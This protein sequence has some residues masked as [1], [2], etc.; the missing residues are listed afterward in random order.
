MSATLTPSNA[1]DRVS[2]ISGDRKI[3]QV[4]ETGHV[5]AVA[6]GT[7]K[8]TAQTQS[9]KKAVC[10][11]KVVKKA[12]KATR[13]KLNKRKA[14]LTAGGVLQLKATLAPVG[15]TDELKWSSSNRKVASVDSN[16][17]V[18]AKKAG[19]A[20]IKVKAKSGKSAVCTVTVK[21]PAKSV[22]INKSAVT[23]KVG[24]HVQ[25]KAV[26]KP[27]KS[28][29]RLKWSSSDKKIARV[30]NKGRVTGVKKGKATV[31]V[32]AS[33]G[34]TAKCKVTVI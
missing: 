27:A 34:K 6:V 32:K 3:A 8:I 15:S 10:T 14:T 19:K 1:T 21:Q 11:V 30:D 29:D 17:V 28:S 22:R 26:M 16:G 20:K 31:T 18:I 9:G 4:D 24:K 5:T 23:V 7:T 13:V 33:S 2:Y 12:A 25:L